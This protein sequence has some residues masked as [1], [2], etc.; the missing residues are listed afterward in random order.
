MARRKTETAVFRVNI[1]VPTGA[2][3]QDCENYIRKAVQSDAG[4][5]DPADPM[6]NL[7]ASLVRVML[8][9]RHVHY[10]DSGNPNGN[11]RTNGKPSD[12]PTRGG[13]SRT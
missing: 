3:M 12:D 6:F 7:D 11:R 9:E 2:N 5:L 4:G 1:L 13:G 8:Q 10:T